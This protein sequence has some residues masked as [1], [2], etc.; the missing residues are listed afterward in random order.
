MVILLLVSGIYS[1]LSNVLFGD[2]SEDDDDPT[3]TYFC[4]KGYLISFTIANKRNHIAALAIQLG[5]DLIAVILLML[6]FH[7]ARYQFRTS[8]AEVTNRTVAPSDYTIMID[9]VPIN[10]TNEEILQWVSKLATKERPLNVERIVRSYAISTYVDL[11]CLNNKLVDQ[12][13]ALSKNKPLSQKDKSKIEEIDGEIKDINEQLEQI[14]KDGIER[15]AVAFVTFKTT[16]R[17]P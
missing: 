10:A 11:V 7:Y 9:G 13:I 15:H 1:L 6:F 4:V 8:L 12:K 2:C 3:K 16:Q 5:L 14:R 17:K